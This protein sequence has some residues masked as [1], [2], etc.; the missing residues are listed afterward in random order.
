[1]LPVKQTVKCPKD[2]KDVEIKTCVTCVE[3]RHMGYVG[4]VHVTMKC[5]F[6]EAPE[7]ERVR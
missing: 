7:K 3:W 6:G 5:G 2:N 1:M 4:T